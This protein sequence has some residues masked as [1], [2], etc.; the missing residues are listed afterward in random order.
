MQILDI[1]SGLYELFTRRIYTGL[2]NIIIVII[3][4]LY[5]CTGMYNILTRQ[6]KVFMGMKQFFSYSPIRILRVYNII[7]PTYNMY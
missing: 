1:T 3:P 4:I 5:N 7:K 2:P 6:T